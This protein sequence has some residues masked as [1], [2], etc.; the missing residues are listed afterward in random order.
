MHKIDKMANTDALNEVY[1]FSIRLGDGSQVY[2]VSNVFSDRHG[3]QSLLPS[4]LTKQ[5][6]QKQDSKHSNQVSSTSSYSEPRSIE[7]SESV[8][9]EIGNIKT[10]M[11]IEIGKVKN[12]IQR[13]TKVLEK[14]AQSIGRT[15]EKDIQ[16][17]ESKYHASVFGTL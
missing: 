8:V 6:S 9:S 17:A 2:A 15:V 14:D 7:N 13:E 12:E 5:S 16:R 4:L 11:A 3:D 1:Q 10:K